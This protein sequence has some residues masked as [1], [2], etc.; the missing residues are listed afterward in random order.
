MTALFQPL[1]S[2]ATRPEPS[3]RV[4]P[5]CPKHTFSKYQ[6]AAL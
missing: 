4:D 3:V 6:Y 2:W 5:L 1:M